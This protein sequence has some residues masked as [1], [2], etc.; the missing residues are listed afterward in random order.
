M[1]FTETWLQELI[2]DS[3]VTIGGFQT[4]RADRN[5]ESGK[6]K[7]G[8][9]VVLV[10]N[11]WCNPGHIHVKEHVCNPDI[12][13]VAIGLRPY[14]L[15]REFT[16][17]IFVVVYIPPMA[18]TEAACDVIN[19]VTARL[20]TKHPSAFIAISG[21]FN[22]VS[23]STTLPT[24]HQFVKCPTRENKTLDLLYANAKDAY[25]STAL[26]P[27]GRSDHNLVLLTPLYTPIVQHQPA[28][29][30]TVRRW[31]QEALEDLRG[32]L[33]ATNLD[34]LCVPHGDDID[35][36]VDCVTDYINFCVDNTIPTKDV[37][38]FSNNKPWITSDLKALLLTSALKVKR[39]QGRLKKTKELVVDFRRKKVKP[40]PV[41][42]HGS[43][44]E[45]VDS[46]KYLGVH[47]YD[48]LEWSKNIEVIYKKGQSRLY[49][50]R[51]GCITKL[52]QFL[53]DHLL[54]IGAVGIGVACL[55]VRS[56]IKL[57]YRIIYLKLI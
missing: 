2:L 12:E 46:Y 11:R 3:N 56:F 49:F 29:M 35:S 45:M 48:R 26:P 7:G 31:S 52:E 28:T 39:E 57:M 19:T 33:E 21:D 55:Q 25:S 4:V 9:L 17:A 40:T 32:A 42:I 20:Q 37:H 13:L 44:M 30:S 27:L 16:C 22:H 10:N 41:Y 8:G 24:F 6:R 14:Y 51:G 1:C 15:P 5:T 23:V 47:I 18:N 34:V 43:G 50:L 38:C 36:M 54:I 53:A